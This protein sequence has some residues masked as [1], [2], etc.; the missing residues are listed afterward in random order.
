M[1]FLNYLN[2]FSKYVRPQ[3]HKHRTEKYQSR[4]RLEEL[5]G[6]MVLST[7]GAAR[8]LSLELGIDF[9]VGNWSR[10]PA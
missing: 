4:P 2:R 8:N 9:D 5:E 6:R 7:L 10:F 3:L 1:R